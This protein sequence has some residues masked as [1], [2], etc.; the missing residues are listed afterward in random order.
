MDNPGR[1]HLK[2]VIKVNIKNGT[3]RQSAFGCDS[4]EE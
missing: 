4:Q 3:K 2:Q 1:H